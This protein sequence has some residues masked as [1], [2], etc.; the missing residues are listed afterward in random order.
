M[1]EKIGEAF[2]ARG[3]EAAITIGSAAEL[4]AAAKRAVGQGARVI[5]AGGGDGTVST[6]ASVV[7]G[8]ATA[9]GVLPLG[10]LN[11]FAKDLGIPLALEAAVETIRAGHTATVDV[12]SVNDRTFINNSSLG[13]YPQ[14]VWERERLRRQGR[15]RWTAFAHAV[16]YV[17]A[18][19]RRLHAIVR[20][21]GERRIVRT[22]F[23]FVGNN[24]YH[25]QGLQMGG[26]RNLTSGDLHL[27]MAPGMTRLA[28]VR[29]LLKALI[30][31][32]G[33]VDRFESLLVPE[34]VI[35]ARRRRLAVALDGELTVLRPPLHYRIRPAALRVLVPVPA[36][37]E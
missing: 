25:T 18:H 20:R 16:A 30:G 21:D 1:P 11:H 27:C 8:T 10:T 14:L 6:V 26:R 12:G 28:V 32:L 5:V 7:A 15:H 9:L 36:A 29:V 35:E 24:E 34:V 37:G 4:R 33:G 13:L 17:W 2:R 31:R 22:P 19:Y 3:V 23:V